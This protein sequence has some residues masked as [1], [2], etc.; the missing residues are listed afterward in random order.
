MTFLLRPTRLER[1][2]YNVTIEEPGDKLQ[3]LFVTVSHLRELA[4]RRVSST[5]K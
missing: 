4:M 1:M 5:G 2:R 3:P